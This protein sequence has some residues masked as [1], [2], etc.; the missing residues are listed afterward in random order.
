MARTVQFLR[1]SAMESELISPTKSPSPSK[2]S[3]SK[4]KELHRHTIV[5]IGGGTAGLTVAARLLRAGQSDVAVI[6]PSEKHYYQPLWTLVGAGIVQPDETERTEES[7]IPSGCN[8][9][10]DYAAEIDPEAKKVRLR[11][12]NEVAYDYLVIAPG[13]QL[14]W[15]KIPGMRQ[16]LETDYV[17]SNYD[18]RL[19]PKTWRLIE[20]FKGGTA[21]FM[22]PPGAIKCAGAPQKIMYLA[23]DYFRRTGKADRSKVVFASA[24][25]AIF[26]VA[27]FRA[28]LEKVIE[29]YGIDTRFQHT[30][31][32]IRPEQREA[33]FDAN[34]GG[35]I[36]RRVIQYDI[37]HVVPPQSAPDFIKK[38]PIATKEGWAAAD[39]YT[40][41]HPSYPNIFALGDAS[42]LPTSRTGAAVRKQAPVLVKNLL[43]V[44]E[45]KEP[46][47]KY[48]GYASCPLVLSYETLLLA[49]FDYDGKPAPS[50]PLINTI[51]E[52]HDMYL[53][54]RYALPWLYWNLMLKGLA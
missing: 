28:V 21:L 31:V 52:R 37:M 27:E 44:M 33:V 49:E 24:G 10:K 16:A 29:R 43:A 45:G 42:S 13:I 12:G 53:L 39:K 34:I 7:V 50:I 17:S 18:F 14:D 25:A 47:A 11:S 9:I 5:I 30:M 20:N 48:D 1:P 46:S 41:Q 4:T 22:H 36:E 8:W 15:D 38:S 26:G 54:K 32:E 6:E 2:R 35:N 23:A 40:L 51:K 19:A 3:A